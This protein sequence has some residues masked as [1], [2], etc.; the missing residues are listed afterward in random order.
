MRNVI[1]AL[2]ASV[3]AAPA[4]AGGVERS[5]QPISILFEEG[6]YL[7]FGA[8]YAQP[9]VEGNVSPLLGGFA[10]GNIANSFFTGSIGYKADLGDNWSYAI[11][12]DQP[13]GA[14]VL[15]PAVSPL[16]TLSAELK[17]TALTGVLRYKFDGGFSAYAGLRSVWT[18]GTVAIPAIPTI[19]PAP[20]T[21]SSNTDQAFGYMLG[22]AYEKPEIALRV[23]LTYNSAVTHDF[24]VQ[25][26]FG[27]APLAPTAFSTNI[28]ESLTLDFRSG[29]VENTLVFG[30]VRW[31]NWKDFVIPAPALG[32][33]IVSYPKN[34]MT[35]TLG[36]GRKFN[37]NWSGSISLSHDTGTGNPT[38]NLGPIG[39]RNSIGLGVSYTRNAMTISGGLQYSRIGQATTTLGS[40]FD[41]NSTIG[42][43]IRVGFSF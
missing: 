6:R 37:E 7:E 41:D 33:T 16:G 13:I 18:S 3:A 42:A 26:T 20:Y 22:V 29:V 5:T 12:V 23:S 43:G 2:A 17:S 19:V 9:S 1:L 4:F 21:L 28:P 40:N 10:T 39:K 11:I 8:S 35:Y 24:D 15:Y 27:G 25:E 36:V 34:S 14:D 38:S 31:V 30:S 32:T